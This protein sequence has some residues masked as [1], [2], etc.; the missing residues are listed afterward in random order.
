MRQC[1]DSSFVME[2]HTPKNDYVELDSYATSG[3][4]IWISGEQNRTNKQTRA[5]IRPS[6]THIARSLIHFRPRSLFRQLIGHER[7][8][9]RS[10]KWMFGLRRAVRHRKSAS[11]LLR[12]AQRRKYLPTKY[13]Q[14]GKF[15]TMQFICESPR[16][17]MI[18][19]VFHAINA[20]TMYS[21][22]PTQ[23]E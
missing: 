9:F 11:T 12:Y 21:Y 15:N 22:L 8:H 2:F 20:N 17:T 19:H 6:L 23:W 14:R 5:V 10:G 18:V 16:S 3:G 7:T 13:L 4:I 1:R